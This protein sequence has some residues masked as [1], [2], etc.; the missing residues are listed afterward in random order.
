MREIV[1]S[2]SLEIIGGGYQSDVEGLGFSGGGK[3]YVDFLKQHL[4]KGL[5]WSFINDIWERF[6]F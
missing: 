1:L 3:C 5:G 6:R 2:V 4:K